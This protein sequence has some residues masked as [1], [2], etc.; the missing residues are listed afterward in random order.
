MSKIGIDIGLPETP[1]EYLLYDLAFS[2]DRKIGAILT[3]NKNNGS[4]FSSTVIIFNV[5]SPQQEAKYIDLNFMA[6]SIA[7]SAD[8]SVLAAG[9]DEG[10]L[11]LIATATGEITKKLFGHHSYIHSLSFSHD[12]SKLYSASREKASIFHI[13]GD[14]LNEEVLV[15]L[16]EDTPMSAFA[17]NKDESAFSYG[18]NGKIF[19]K[20]LLETAVISNEPIINSHVKELVFSQDGKLILSSAE[21]GRLAISA[22]EGGTLLVTVSI[23][24][25]GDWITMTP[26][27]FFR[28]LAWG[29]EVPECRARNGSVLGRSG[30]P[31]AVPSG[32]R[33]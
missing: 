22:A 16:P 10:R 26:E 28:R 13:N 17:I 9:A 4:A 11:R 24:Q 5:N 3:R 31:G 2:A 23:L 18:Y 25:A 8:G 20:K 1:P 21:N 27:G 33:P 15:S 19:I 32:P 29:C 30:L 6:S 7:L 14:D 12:G